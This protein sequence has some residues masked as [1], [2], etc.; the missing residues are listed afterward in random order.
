[1]LLLLGKGK[2]VGKAQI[3][4]P[5]IDSLPNA[6]GQKRE[7]MIQNEVARKIRENDWDESNI[8]WTTVRSQYGNLIAEIPVMADAFRLDGIR[9]N[10]DF[11][12][13]QRLADMLDIYQLTTHVADLIN[14]QAGYW[15]RPSNQPWQGKGTDNTGSQTRRMID[16]SRIVDKRFKEAELRE[17]GNPFL[18]NNPA[19]CWVNH[20]RNWEKGLKYGA[21]YGMY[22][23]GGGMI[24]GPIPGLWH[25]LNHVDYSQLFWAMGNKAVLSHAKG[26]F[27][28]VEISLKTMMAMP[29]LKPLIAGKDDLPELRHPGIAKVPLVA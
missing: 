24:Q 1:M 14:A 8:G 9:I 28:P 13:G 11:V 25:T 10:T 27:E 17:N 21:N 22:H 19:K 3:A 20:S 7:V 18:K 2:S 16:H 5:F 29:E 23:P 12:T 4:G 15:T 6:W 26:D